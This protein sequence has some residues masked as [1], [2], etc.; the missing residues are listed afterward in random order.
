MPRSKGKRI[1]SRNGKKAKPTSPLPVNHPSAALK[2]AAFADVGSLITDTVY[3]NNS[4]QSLAFQRTLQAPEYSG[5]GIDGGF[6]AREYLARSTQQFEWEFGADAIA[7]TDVVTGTYVEKRFNEVMSAGVFRHVIEGSFDYDSTGKLTGGTATGF[8]RWIGPEN[9]GAG[10]LQYVKFDNPVTIAPDG[11]QGI[12]L[13][14]A[15]EW[16]STSKA[17]GGDTFLCEAGSTSS[18]LGSPG[19]PECRGEFIKYPISKYFEGDWWANP[20]A[21][22]L[23]PG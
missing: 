4:P 18:T 17:H 5:F 1:R 9:A 23:I 12:H 3:N 11:F 2:S 6:G 8:A 10:S 19:S 13:A 15:A 14:T 7:V 21:T 22:D 16:A 20:F